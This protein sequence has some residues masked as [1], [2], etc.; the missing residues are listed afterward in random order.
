MIKSADI[1][2]KMNADT[3]IFFDVDGALIDTD[4]ANFLSYKETISFV[5][6]IRD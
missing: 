2:L 4:L 3:T 6:Q 5:L 1:N